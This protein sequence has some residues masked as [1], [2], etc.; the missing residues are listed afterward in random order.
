MLRVSSQRAVGSPCSDAAIAPSICSSAHTTHSQG[1]PWPIDVSQHG[2]SRAGVNCLFPTNSLTRRGRV[3][4]MYPSRRSPMR[5]SPLP[6]S[7]V[8]TPAPD[9]NVLSRPLF[10]HGSLAQM[11]FLQVFFTAA[12]SFECSCFVVKTWGP[13]PLAVQGARHLYVLPMPPTQVGGGGLPRLS[14][15][16]ASSCF[17]VVVPSWVGLTR[18]RSKRTVD[19]RGWT[20]RSPPAGVFKTDAV[21]SPRAGRSETVGSRQRVPPSVSSREA[22]VLKGHRDFAFAAPVAWW[23]KH[24]CYRLHPQ[25]V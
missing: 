12:P 1:K 19:V 21:S 7:P 15:P 3:S 14:R 18:S 23:D 11:F 4:P 6:A 10:S 8:Q 9:P 16:V 5:L 20:P 24:R 13:R 2:R 22:Q 17:L 25:P